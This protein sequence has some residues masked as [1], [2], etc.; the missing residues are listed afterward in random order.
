MEAAQKQTR[1]PGWEFTDHCCRV[2]FGRL[3]EHVDDQGTKIVRCAGCGTTVQD[4]RRKLC[5]CGMKL[6]TGR[7]AGYRCVKHKPTPEMPAE[8]VVEFIGIEEMKNK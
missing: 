5:C 2:C 6:R 4:S 8:I 7:N 3:L 1:R